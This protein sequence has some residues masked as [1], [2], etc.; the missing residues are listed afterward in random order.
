MDHHQNKKL[1]CLKSIFFVYISLFFVFGLV[2]PLF[3]KRSLFLKNKRYNNHFQS[4]DDWAASSLGGTKTYKLTIPKTTITRLMR[5]WPTPVP[6]FF[7][8]KVDKM[9]NNAIQI[10]NL[11]LR[12]IPALHKSKEMKEAPSGSSWRLSFLGSKYATAL[13]FFPVDMLLFV[14]WAKMKRL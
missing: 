12:N 2:Q 6:F 4:P 11:F 8:Q 7:L 5:Y 10:N 14:W 13:E 3:I 9:K 1:L